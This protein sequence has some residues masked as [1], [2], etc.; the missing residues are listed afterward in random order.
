MTKITQHELVK[1]FYLKNPN[2]GIQHQEA[3]DWL[4]EEYKKEQV[5]FLEILIE[6]FVSYMKRGF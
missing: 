3:V 1:E 6:P 2:R 5:K 4:T